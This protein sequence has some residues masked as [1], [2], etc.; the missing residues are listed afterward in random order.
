MTATMTT[1]NLAEQEQRLV[2]T[3][4]GWGQ[5]VTI[6]DALPDWCS[7]RMIYLD[8][9]LTFLTTSRH[10]DRLSK[11]LGQL[12][13]AVADGCGIVWEDAGQATFRREDLGSGVE[14]DD[15]FYFG[16]NAERMRGP[17]NIDLTTQPPPDL[18][19]EVE[20]THPA[21]DAMLVYGRLGV[22]EVWRFDAGRGTVGFWLRRD[23][24][25]YAPAPR[26][27]G[28]PLLEPA[29]VL[30]QLRLAEELGS[31][32]WHAQLDGWVRD[33]LLPRRGA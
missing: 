2:L 23:D 16:E 22:P 19:I 11:R 14:G 20:V 27:A 7:L 13:V 1:P 29:N 26:S 28:L 24:G 25:I 30:G 12:V 3:G 33:V 21:D 18:A 8:G 4:V 31:S 9:R 5:Y 32:R 15:T 10:H 6:S 17:Q